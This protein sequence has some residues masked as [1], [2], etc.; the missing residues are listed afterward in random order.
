MHC[1]LAV[2]A[3]VCGTLLLNGCAGGLPQLGAPVASYSPA[4]IFSPE[5][6][7]QT[8]IDDTHYRVEATGTEATPKE[9]VEK[10]ARARAAQIGVETKQKYYKVTSVQHS[11][12]CKKRRDSYKG[13]AT[14]PSSRP[15]VVLDVVY[16]DTQADPEFADANE[17]YV[18]MQAD[19]ASETVTPEARDAALQA[20]RA[21]CGEATGA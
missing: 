11:V 16:A 15:N 19:L 8:K 14:A 6:Y 10:M 21:S 20:T 1:R 3:V 5:G 4:T 7:G 13:E 9:R 12:A 2:A 17:S 18:Q